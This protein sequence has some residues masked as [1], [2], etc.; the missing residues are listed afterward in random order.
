M[1]TD[2]KTLPAFPLRTNNAYRHC[3][4]RSPTDFSV[5]SSLRSGCLK[6]EEK[7]ETSAYDE[8]EVELDGSLPDELEGLPAEMSV[9][10]DDETFT[11]LPAE[12]SVS[13]NENSGPQ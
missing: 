6:I 10:T 4:P 1:K 7:K 5:Y 3:C 9:E 2:L 8:E 11:N 13:M 12:T